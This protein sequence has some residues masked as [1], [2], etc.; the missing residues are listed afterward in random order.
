MESITDK[1]IEAM[2]HQLE[3]VQDELNKISDMLNRINDALLGSEYSPDTGLVNEIKWLKKEVYD[4]KNF[5]SRLKWERATALVIGTA[6]GT[7]IGL[8]INAGYLWLR[9]K[10]K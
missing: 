2:E 3:D 9:L 6:I 1:K 10:G 4:L 7:V 8:I 5:I